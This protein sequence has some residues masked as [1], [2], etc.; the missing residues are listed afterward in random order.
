M[1]RSSPAEKLCDVHGVARGWPHARLTVSNC[2][3]SHLIERRRV[4]P[5]DPEVS[6]LALT[7][8][9]RE[10]YR[11]TEPRSGAATVESL[12][13]GT[14]RTHRLQV[15]HRC[16]SPQSEPL[17]ATNRHELYLAPEDE[18]YIPFGGFRLFLVQRRLERDGAPVPVG[19]KAFDILQRPGR[20]GRARSS[21]RLSS[22]SGFGRIASRMKRQPQVSHHRVA[23]G[24]G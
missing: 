22:C 15:L 18:A 2:R 19:G 5:E 8:Q 24:V 13:H 9:S 3:Q 17:R 12:R 14:L 10:G 1:W 21:V 20:T 6:G 11:W 7:G 16:T 4:D 23:E